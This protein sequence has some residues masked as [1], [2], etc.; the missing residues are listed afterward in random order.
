MSH[1]ELGT[2]ADPWTKVFM[3]HERR[4]REP[5]CDECG[6]SF[7]CDAVVMARAV[8]ALVEALEK[9]GTHQGGCLRPKDDSACSC[10]WIPALA[11]AR[12]EKP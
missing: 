10:G 8:K 9:Y 11:A 2:T 4:D 3:R 7:P 12:G 6:A 5:L 1:T